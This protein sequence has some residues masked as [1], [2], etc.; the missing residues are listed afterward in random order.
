MHYIIMLCFL[1]QELELEE[2]KDDAVV[3]PPENWPHEGKI[4]FANVNLRYK[5]NGPRAFSDV[6]FSVNPCEKVGIVGRTGAGK[7][8]YLLSISFTDSI[9]KC[10]T[11]VSKG[12]R[13]SYQLYYAC[14]PLK[15]VRFWLMR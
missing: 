6:S 4:V 15:V 2:Q 10:S 7:L 11:L 8:I 14:I 9:N 3:Q 12:K 13:P 1:N 5:E